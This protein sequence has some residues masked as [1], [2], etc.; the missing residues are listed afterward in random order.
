MANFQLRHV[1]NIICSICAYKVYKEILK[2]I[3][4]LKF[5]NKELMHK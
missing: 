3:Y 1:N 5:V 4:G 2:T